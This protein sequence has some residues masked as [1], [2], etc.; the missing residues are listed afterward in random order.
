MVS[1]R[2]LQNRKRSCKLILPT[3]L[4]SD[5]MPEITL[6]ILMNI[7]SFLT[8]F[9]KILRHTFLFQTTF[10]NLILFQFQAAPFAEVF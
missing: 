9:V 8:E 5:L 1:S 10:R 2:E 6:K 4:V 3:P 7:R